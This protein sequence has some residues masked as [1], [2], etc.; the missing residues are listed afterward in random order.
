SSFG[1][2]TGRVCKCFSSTSWS[3]QSPRLFSWCTR[4]ASIAIRYTSRMD[5]GMPKQ[6]LRLDMDFEKKLLEETGA[7]PNRRGPPVSPD[8]AWGIQISR[9]SSLRSWLRSGALWRRLLL[10]SALKLALHSKQI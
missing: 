2:R 10:H 1:D 9:A 6:Q 4:F 5:D 3:T 8:H 7:D